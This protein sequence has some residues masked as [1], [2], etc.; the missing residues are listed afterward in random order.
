VG[1]I[2]RALVLVLLGGVVGYFAHSV[3]ATMSPKPT[4]YVFDDKRFQNSLD[5]V[6]A[7]GSRT[8]QGVSYP[9]NTMAI[10]CY[11]D[12]MEC[13]MASVEGIG[14]DMCQ[15]GRMEWP[16]YMPITKW[17]DQEIVAAEDVA[18]ISCRKT[19]LSIDRHFQTVVLVVEPV[20]IT[21]T[22]CAGASTAIDKSTLENSR[23][24]SV[25]FPK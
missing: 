1:S 9:D 6:Y 24:Q 25:M 16:S 13:W 17:T 4:V 2:A 23:W 15:I 11:R 10:G 8:G 21:S 19:T 18:P 14:K 20:N 3:H 5:F 12:K 22:F 7:A